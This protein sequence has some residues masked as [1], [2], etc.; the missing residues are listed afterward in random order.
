MKKNYLVIT[1]EFIFEDRQWE[2]FNTY[3][4]SST[5][6]EILDIYYKKDN[7]LILNIIEY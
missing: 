4:P 7:V 2:L 1:K 5:L 6:K 3:I